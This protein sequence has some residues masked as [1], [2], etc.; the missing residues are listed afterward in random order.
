MAKTFQFI[1]R[2]LMFSLTVMI[3]LSGNAVGA[4]TPLAHTAP[5]SVGLML[6]LS[7]GTVIAQR[8]GTSATWYRLTPDIHGSYVNGTWTTLAAMHDTR[9]YFSSDVL[10]DGRLF[11]AGGE[12]GTGEKTAEVYDPLCNAWT[13]TP[14]SGQ[15][16]SD[17]ISKVITNGNV[18]V[19]P[20]GPSNSGFTII[21]NYA[22]NTWTTGPKLFRGSYQDEASWVKLPDNSILTIDPFGTNSERYIPASN[23]WIND[24]NVPVRL[25]DSFGFEM[26]GGLLLPDGRAFFL[27][28]TGHSAYYTP[29][30]STNAGTWAAGPDIPNAMGTPDA[31]A[32]MMVNGK[33][34][35]AASPVPTSANHFPTPTSF[36]EFDYVSNLFT[37]VNAPTGATE[38]NSTYYTVMLDLPDGT[39][40]FSHFSSQLYVYTPDGSPLAAGKPDISAI[41]Q[42]ADS[43]FHLTGTGL[44]GICEGAVYG[45]DWQMDGN[46]PIVRLTDVSNKVY[47]ARTVNWSSTGVMT[48]AT[49]VSTDFVLPSG[50]ASGTYSLVVVANGNSSDPVSFDVSPIKISL[51]ASAT[52]GAAPVTATVTL[53]LAPVSDLVVNLAS[54][55]TSRATVPATVTVLAGQTTAT[56]PVTIVDDQ[57]LNGSQAVMISA[58]ANGYQGGLAYIVVQD[59]E[60]AT[61]AITPATGLVSTGYV[62]GA[63]SP[64]ST[65]FTLTNSGNIVLGWTAAKTVSWLTLSPTSG[66]IQ[67]GASTT[68]T[69]TINS[70]ANSLVASNYTDTITFNNTTNGNGNTT[71]SVSLTVST[72]PVPVIS[73]F[74]P[75]SGLTNTS[76]IITGTNFN[77]AST[78]KFNGVSATFTVNSNTQITTA[79][80]TTATTGTITVT[81]P[82]GTATSASNFTVI[83]P[84]DLS[85][86]SS[87]IGNFTQG[88]IGDVYTI[89]VTN[90]GAGASSSTVT[91]SNALP[92]GLTATAISGAG[93][94]T[95]LG[96]LTATRSDVLATNAAYPAIT[97][98]VNVA[99]N[100]SA[101]VTNTVIVIGGGDL[102][103]ANNTNKDI[104]TVAAA[105]TPS[106]TTGSASGVDT[107]SAT[108]NATVNP[109]NQPTTVVLQYGLTTNYGSAVNVSG[110]LTGA[111]AQAAS[112]SLTNLTLGTL[113]HYRVTATNVIGAANGLDQT[114][115]TT[116]PDLSVTSSHAGVF[117][118]GQTNATYTIV[119]TN[120]GNAASSGMVT[121]AD[122]L[123]AGL[124]ATA[125]GGTGWTTNLATL[126]CTRSDAL[127]AGAIY[128][129]ITLTVTV[130]ANAPTSVTNLATVSGGGEISTTNNT[131]VDSTAITVTSTQRSP[132]YGSY[133]AGGVSLVFSNGVFGTIYRIQV[134]TNLLDWQ[135]LATNTAP[136]NGVIQFTDPQATNLQSRMYR[137]TK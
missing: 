137:I 21:Y 62:G 16:F 52:E 94:T 18:L 115:T 45:D 41:T 114:F 55:P 116:A 66:T 44:N 88:D 79:V 53:P 122:S 14:V 48:G 82:G 70:G 118:Q 75:T 33:I 24:A 5:S 49:P 27:G 80:P 19:S 69:A 77:S 6:L 112:A 134:S 40:L 10:K 50:L 100:A 37:A 97:I 23:T 67:P 83:F 54:S 105:A 51:A 124:A 9:L 13:M 127:A 29:S 74:N 4:W 117:A 25:Y 12:Y 123:P 57:I 89:T 120:I 22:S 7:D 42:N 107:N 15:S 131:S 121:V 95:T 130:A 17:S 36:Y 60:S 84:P 72:W 104:T 102:N 91:V 1:F 126:T 108:L 20:V 63:F 106:A 59:N 68:L 30:G 71:R 103:L 128:P 43:T 132:L 78:V 56:F 73:S 8:S 31:A 28:A 34:L 119:V 64:A 101:S 2:V 99:S 3:P 111:T 135:N 129:S 98:I 109:N 61:L 46:Y 93:W 76:V 85:V 26:G 90:S 81:T 92:A 110:T 35:C 96:T 87:H 86:A 133:A 11:V 113:Y 65:S 136:A 58:S 125:I 32:A 38:N 39:V 47:Y